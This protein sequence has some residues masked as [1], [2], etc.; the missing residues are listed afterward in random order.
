MVQND[1]EGLLN[2][3]AVN[4]GSWVLKCYEAIICQPS[5]TSYTLEE[6]LVKVNIH[7][8][9]WMKAVVGSIMLR[10]FVHSL[11]V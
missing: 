2:Q 11:S 6:L 8:D 5:T 7:V 10:D 4:V 1:E 3:E 9:K